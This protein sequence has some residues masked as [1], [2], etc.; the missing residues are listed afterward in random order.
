MRFEAITMIFNCFLAYKIWPDNSF[1]RELGVFGSLPGHENSGEPSVHQRRWPRCVFGP[2]T[3]FVELPGHAA[4]DQCFPQLLASCIAKAPQKTHVTPIEHV[5]TLKSKHAY[6]LCKT[7]RPSVLC[8]LSR[9]H[10]LHDN[11]L[12]FSQ[13]P[14]KELLGCHLNKTQQYPVAWKLYKVRRFRNLKLKCAHP[15]LKKKKKKK[16][17]VPGD[18]LLCS[19]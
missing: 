19:L 6:A 4:D 10:W 11:K 3:Q 2:A 5:E 7:L 8:L 15:Q 17:L 1:N 13:D 14:R 12:S 18:V 9:S 16:P